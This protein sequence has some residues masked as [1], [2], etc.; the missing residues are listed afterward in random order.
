MC[1]SPAGT[2]GEGTKNEVVG[3]LVNCCAFS[4]TEFSGT[5]PSYN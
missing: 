4:F 2:S 5:D 1:V 3:K